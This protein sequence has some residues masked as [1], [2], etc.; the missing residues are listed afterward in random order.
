MADINGL[1][2]HARI[3]EMASPDDI[4]M[5]EML[6]KSA[7][8]WFTNAGVKPRKGS[9]LYDLGVYML[10]TAWFNQRGDLSAA[11]LVQ[12]PHGVYSIRAQLMSGDL[13]DEADGDS[14]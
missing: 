11:T 3:D 1:K 6:L 4:S 9:P 5:L 2:R 14:K 13:A 10:A 7:V 8:E 12:V